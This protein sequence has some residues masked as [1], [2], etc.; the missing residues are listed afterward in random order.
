MPEFLLKLLGT[1]F[2]AAL[3]KAGTAVTGHWRPWWAAVLIA[4]VVVFGGFLLLGDS[5]SRWDR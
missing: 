1:A 4:V 2:L 3:I 5:D